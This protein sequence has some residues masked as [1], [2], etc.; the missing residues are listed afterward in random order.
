MPDVAFQGS[1]SILENLTEIPDKKFRKFIRDLSS[2]LISE[3]HYLLEWY[4]K[5][6]WYLCQNSGNYFTS[7]SGQLANEDLMFKNFE[8][9]IKSKTNEKIHFF[10]SIFI[11]KPIEPVLK[12]NKVFDELNFGNEFRTK[13]TQREK[14]TELDDLMN[15]D[16]K[17]IVDRLQKK[18]EDF[19]SLFQEP[20]S[21]L[22]STNL[23]DKLHRDKINT[24]EICPNSKLCASG[25]NDGTIKFID[26]ETMQ[27]FPEITIK[28][29]EG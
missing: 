28:E 19:P 10:K 4:S 18:R 16:Y 22:L 23:F 6:V 9:F 12:K 26:L 17:I 25:S 15:Y 5:S 20:F 2:L 8:K 7:L 29:P 1:T 3:S 14:M 11:D 27:H 24:L 21:N 13:L